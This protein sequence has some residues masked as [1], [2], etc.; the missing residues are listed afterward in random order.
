MHKRGYGIRVS[1][2]VY[3]RRKCILLEIK[4]KKETS[5][6]Y[7]A[8]AFLSLGAKL[9]NIDR[10]NPKHMS[11][12]FET[13]DPIPPTNQ[14][15]LSQIP[16]SPVSGFVNTPLK[17]EVVLD[18]DDLETQWANNKLMVSASAYAESIRRM[19]SLVHSKS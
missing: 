15:N 19:K 2:L 16:V 1:S 12:Q 11:F 3:Q 8:A 13:H 4:M 17:M 7:M 10:E 6:I 18:L 9:T 5:D 14:I